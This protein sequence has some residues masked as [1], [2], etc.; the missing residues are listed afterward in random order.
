MAK[1]ALR[2]RLHLASPFLRLWIEETITPQI[3]HQFIHLNAEFIRIHF[4][5]LLQRESP[6]VQ[7]R[8]E[9]NITEAWID[10]KVKFF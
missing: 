5:E 9:A 3:F 7:T 2:S 6:A 8:A 1:T 4:S 10:L